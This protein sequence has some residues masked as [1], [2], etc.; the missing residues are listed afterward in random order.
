MVEYFAKAFLPRFWCKSFRWYLQAQKR[1]G[2]VDEKEKQTINV[3]SENVAA[4][5]DIRKGN[6]LANEHLV[7]LKM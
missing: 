3:N 6:A 4:R 5:A 7:L 1:C 2:I